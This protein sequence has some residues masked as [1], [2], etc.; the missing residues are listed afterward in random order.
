MV[1]EKERSR[2]GLGDE[3]TRTWLSLSR[4][5]CRVGSE[6][7]RKKMVVERRRREAVIE[8]QRRRR[9]RLW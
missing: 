1:R 3:L 2:V 8:R 7:K 5:S 9:R 6:G 4:T